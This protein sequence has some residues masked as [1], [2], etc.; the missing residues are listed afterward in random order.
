MKMDMLG[1][2]PII[3]YA[4][5][6]RAILN[7][8]GNRHQIVT[9]SDT[10]ILTDDSVQN[11]YIHYHLISPT[12]EWIADRFFWAPAIEGDSAAW[13]RQL[14][15]LLA[16]IDPYMLMCVNR[17]IVTTELDSD[18]DAVCSMMELTADDIP[19]PFECMGF[20]WGD[21]SSVVIN[22]TCIDDI[23]GGMLIDG[24][25]DRSA[26]METR[27]KEFLVTLLSCLRQLAISGNPYLPRKQYPLYERDGR[28]ANSWAEAAYT[29]LL[30]QQHTMGPGMTSYSK[31]LEKD[32]EE[33]CVCPCLSPD[34]FQPAPWYDSFQIYTDIQTCHPRPEH[35]VEVQKALKLF[36]YDTR[37]V[38]IRGEL[39]LVPR[40]PSCILKMMELSTAHI[41]KQTANCMDEY[42]ELLPNYDKGGYGF[43]VYVP[44]ISILQESSCYQEGLPADLFA[45]LKYAAERDCDWLMLDRDCEAVDGLTSYN[46]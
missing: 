14:G 46:W 26:E 21:S 4:A 43:F 24:D 40:C 12:P 45:C 18:I 29:E 44:H 1:N 2:N 25:I 41:T 36:G 28:K 23:I 32:I 8:A 11:Q 22:L 16:K 9:Q 19:Y 39:H 10:D 38:D 30:P 42:Y 27:K 7:D 35:V 3:D 33:I 37:T 31:L 17:I 20:A 13:S 6:R 5:V 34:V 15:E